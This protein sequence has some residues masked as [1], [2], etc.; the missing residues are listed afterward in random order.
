MH[1]FKLFW[2]AFWRSLW[3]HRKRGNGRRLLQ[4]LWRDRTGGWSVWRALW[5]Q[6]KGAIVI[7]PLGMVKSWRMAQC[8][9]YVITGRIPYYLRK[10]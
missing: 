1:G 7:P 5:R 9:R 8:A 4:A 6:R 2:W 3:R 10:I